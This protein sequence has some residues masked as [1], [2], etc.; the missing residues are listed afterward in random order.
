MGK[1]IDV[2]R[3]SDSENQWTGNHH[4]MSWCVTN[5]SMK[6][7]VRIKMLC[8]YPHNWFIELKKAIRCLM[9]MYSTNIW[10]QHETHLKLPVAYYST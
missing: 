9:L 8:F 1:A 10:G 2:N 4:F 7:N 6:D 5:T 3:I